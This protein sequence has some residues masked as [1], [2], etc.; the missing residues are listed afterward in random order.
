MAKDRNADGLRGLAAVSVLV[1]HAVLAFFPAALTLYFSSVAKPGAPQGRVDSLLGTPVLSVLWNGRFAVLVFFVLSGYVLTKS[2]VER[3]D[4]SIARQL[5]VR[6][7]FRLAG[8]VLASAMLAC[9][10][11]SIGAYHSKAVADI[12]WSDWLESMFRVTPDFMQAAKE[13]LYGAIFTGDDFFNP[14]FWTMR[15]EFVGSLLILAYRSLTMTARGTLI[16][17]PIYVVLIATIAPRDYIY[18]F[19][20]LLGTHIND[21]PALKSKVVLY[22]LFILG[23]YFGGVHV[24]PLYVWLD[25]IS[26]D[27]SVRNGLLTILGAALVVYAVKAGAFERILSSSLVQFL[28]RISYSLY[29]VHLPLLLSVACG[30]YLW[31]VGHGFGRVGAASIAIVVYTFT[32]IAVAALFTRLVDEP[33][34]RLTRRLFPGDTTSPPAQERGAVRF[35]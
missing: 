18:F 11:M 28:G 21:L 2:M 8:P 9:V 7:Y 23:I 4:A 1:S 14:V 34:I 16:G 6:R 27:L 22:A 10:L 30:T 33:C 25:A 24:S 31:L 20:F 13:G 15:V 19:A 35:T 29:L 32:T 5:A 12:T 17:F 3:N 26:T